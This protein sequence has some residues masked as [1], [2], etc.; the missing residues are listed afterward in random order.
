MQLAGY[1]K[2]LATLAEEIIRYLMKAGATKEDAQDIAQDAFVKL[3]ETE[4]ILPPANLRAWMYR[5]A[6]S[7][8]YNLYNRKKRYQEIL[9]ANFFH[10]ESWSDVPLPE[11]GLTQALGRL[12]VEEGLLII[13]RYE[14]SL[15]VKEM[16]Q[17]LQR[18]EGA[19]KTQLFRIR[20]KL[21]EYLREED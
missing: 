8:Y 3:L 18:K 1:E 13:M 20:Q 17:V 11:T 12:T 7:R 14:E 4:I 15:S 2:L 21:K 6:I 5:V 9:A 16:A 19:L 10:Q